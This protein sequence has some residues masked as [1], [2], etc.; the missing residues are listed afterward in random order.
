MTVRQAHAGRLADEDEAE[1]ADLR[2]AGRQGERRV[3]GPAQQEHNP[4]ET[5]VVPQEDQRR[6]EEN[7]DR[8]V[9]EDAPVEH[10]PDRDEKDRPEEIFHGFNEV[11]DVFGLDGF[12]QDGPHDKS[13]QCGGKTGFHGK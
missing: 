3:E 5:L 13:P 1:F 11:F 10:H 2:D 8:P 12:R 9:D 4:N 6:H 7:V